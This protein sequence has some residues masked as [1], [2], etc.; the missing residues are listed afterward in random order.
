MQEMIRRYY[1]GVMGILVATLSASPSIADA[2][3]ADWLKK[4]QEAQKQFQQGVDAA[5]KQAPVRQA[6]VAPDEKP[7][8]TQVTPVASPERKTEPG[9]LVMVYAAGDNNLDPFALTDVKE[10]QKVGSG[11]DL[12]IVVLMDRVDYGEWTTARRFLVR[13]PADQG[14]KDSWEES[15]PTCEDLGELNMGDPQTLTSF[16]EWATETYPQPNTMLVLWNH[17]GGWRTATSRAVSVGAGSARSIGPPPKLGL[18][19]LSR[20]IAWDDTNGGDFL[21]MREVR[22]ALEPFAPFTIIGTD[23]CLM[24]M[25]EVAYELRE[26]CAYFIGS[27]DIE[28]G[29]GWP[30]DRWLPPLAENTGMHPEALCKVVVDEYTKSYGL[31]PTTMSAV[32]QAKIPALA[33][34]ID[35]V[36][37]ALI[38][39]TEARGKP[40]VSFKG[41]PWF[42]PSDPDFMDLGAFLERLQRKYPKAVKTAAKE[43]HAALEDAV[44]ANRSHLL[45]QGQGLSIYPGGGY[46]ERDYRAGIIQFARDTRWDELLRELTFHSKAEARAKLSTGNPDRWAVLI[47]VEE[48]EDSK[49]TRLNYSVDDVD[50]LRKVL[51]EHAG[52][53]PENI[54]VLKNGEATASSVRSTL[55]T[56]LPRQVSDQ[57]MVLIYFSGHGGAEPSIRGDV[58]DGTEKYMMLSDSKADDMYGSAIPMS[59]LARIFGRI[60]A[61]K[62]LFAMDSCYSGATDQ[63]EG[64]KGVMREGMKAIGLSDEYL[65]ALTGSSGTVVLTASKASE[66]SMESKSL[67][68]GLFTHFLCQALQGSADSDTDGLISVVELFQFLNMRVPAAAKQMG[69]S[70]H[71]VLKGEISGTFPIAVV[72]PKTEPA[73]AEKE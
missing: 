18:S 53:K 7:A 21:E 10:M 25:V 64:G 11:E 47:G 5:A 12:K 44:I 17:G 72:K 33:E 48:Y 46:D 31:R 30:Y 16:V 54:L 59:E 3:F 34:K 8:R 4:D 52:Y 29:D 70:Q 9:W 14:G 37:C 28:P 69:S 15:L 62:L 43:A 27:E 20:G 36:A 2:G 65:N 63:A 19:R 1:I 67:G 24:G 50:A 60:R 71:P 58:K 22:T 39:H 68:M 41:L 35:A 23:A 13:K 57:D 26:R 66:V 51:I 40:E 73:E 42:T 32:D 49:V 45:L 38:D 61:D 55:G 6:P 56:W